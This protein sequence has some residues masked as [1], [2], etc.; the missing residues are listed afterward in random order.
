MN[1]RCES[2]RTP[3]N[4]KSLTSCTGFPSINSLVLVR[5]RD[6]LKAIAA[7]FSADSVKP[8]F[9]TMTLFGLGLVGRVFQLYCDPVEYSKWLRRPQRVS[10]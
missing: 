8:H 7:D 1:V 9:Y 5:S 3:K 4:L 10:I 6:L 2:K